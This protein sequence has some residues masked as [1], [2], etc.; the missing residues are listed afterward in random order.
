ME[1]GYTSR[2]CSPEGPDSRMGAFEPDSQATTKSRHLNRPLEGRCELPHFLKQGVTSDIVTLGG[3]YH[4]ALSQEVLVQSTNL[5]LCISVYIGHRHSY[6]DRLFLVYYFC[7]KTAK[8][9]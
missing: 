5:F 8:A 6:A 3:I 4:L 2:L 7:R 1:S 9:R